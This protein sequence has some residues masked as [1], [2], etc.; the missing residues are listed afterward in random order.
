MRSGS[1]SCCQSIPREVIH[2]SRTCAYSTAPSIAHCATNGACIPAYCEREGHEGQRS[3]EGNRGRK[4]TR[5]DTTYHAMNCDRGKDGAREREQ[6]SSPISN[7]PVNAAGLL[8]DWSSSM[9]TVSSRCTFIKVCKG[10]PSE[11]YTDEFEHGGSRE[12]RTSLSCCS[13]GVASSSRLV[14]GWREPGPSSG[15]SSAESSWSPSPLVDV[16]ASSPH[17]DSPVV[18][19]SMAALDAR[20]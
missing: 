18:E 8:M 4:R 1:A 19:A 2:L 17:W 11:H 13:S 14:L 6:Y 20:C 15:G 5:G 16:P 9:S 7:R 3:S 10:C 12:T